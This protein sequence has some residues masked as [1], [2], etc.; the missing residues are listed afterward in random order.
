M[1]EKIIVKIILDGDE[2]EFT[3]SGEPAES[4]LGFWCQIVGII[5]DQTLDFIKTKRDIM[6]KL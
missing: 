3:L 5:A 2:K 1:T 4:K 6:L